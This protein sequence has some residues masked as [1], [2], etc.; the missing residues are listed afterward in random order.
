[1]LYFVVDSTLSVVG[2]VN[3]D[4]DTLSGEDAFCG[5]T[6]LLVDMVVDFEVDMVL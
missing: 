1:M 2:G 6:E 5:G 3:D 4:G